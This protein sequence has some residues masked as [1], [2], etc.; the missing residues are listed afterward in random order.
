M[1][2]VGFFETIARDLGGKGQLRLIIQPLVAVLLGMRLGIADAKEGQDPYLLRM[3]WTGK[4]RGSLFKESLRQVVMP[5]T[6]AVAVDV[7]L[8]HHTLGHV[9]PLAALVVGGLLVWLP[10][11]IARALTNRAWKRTHQPRPP[12]P[13]ELVRPA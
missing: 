11:A 1:A 10:F 5:L 9:R 2:A 8:Q 12:Q 3:L 4:Q 7:I 13:P 6:V